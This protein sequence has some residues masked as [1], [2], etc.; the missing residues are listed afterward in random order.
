MFSDHDF[1]MGMKSFLKIDSFLFSFFIFRIY[2]LIY[3]SLFIF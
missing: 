3:F 2:F 1:K